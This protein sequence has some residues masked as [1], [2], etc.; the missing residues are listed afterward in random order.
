MLLITALKY[1][2]D[3]LLRVYENIEPKYN[4]M[5]L[6][7]DQAVRSGATSLKFN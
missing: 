3:L 4:K 5:T 6:K 7:G 2:V 1:F